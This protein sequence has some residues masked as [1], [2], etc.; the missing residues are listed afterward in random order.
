MDEPVDWSGL[1][2][3]LGQ[4]WQVANNSIKPYP[5]GFVIHPLLDLAL[6]WRRANAGT[7]V[8]KVRARGNPLLLQRTDRPDVKTGREAQV[9]LQHA[10]AAALVRGKAG[11]AEFTDSCVA[12]PAVSAMRRKVEV[13]NAAPR[14]RRRFARLPLT[15][16]EFEH[17]H[18]EV[19]LARA[20]DL[21]D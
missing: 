7:V 4:S 6:D 12:D 14:V 19:F 10:V 2:D 18:A 1:L 15:W 21:P 11:L 20:A 8:D 13:G 9:S 3:G 16:L 5:S 17:G